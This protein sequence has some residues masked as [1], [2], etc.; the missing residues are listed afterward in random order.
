MPQ[1]QPRPE[2]VGQFLV[3]YSGFR[4]RVTANIGDHAEIPVDVVLE[5][6]RSAVARPLAVK[7]FAAF[8]VATPE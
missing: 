6:T 3:V 8:H 4:I 5:R 2:H 7:L 1:V